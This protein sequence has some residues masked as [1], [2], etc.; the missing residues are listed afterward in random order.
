[1]CLCYKP[2]FLTTDGIKRP[3]MDIAK[4]K[5]SSLVCCSISDEE[6]RFINIDNWG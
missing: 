4:Q 1:M 6:K 2:L 5:Y 3:V